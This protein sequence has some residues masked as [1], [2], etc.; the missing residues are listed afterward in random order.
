MASA[1]S[2]RPPKPASISP[3][4]FYRSWL[5]WPA[6]SSS[7][8]SLPVGN[9]KRRDQ[10]H[11]CRECQIRRNGLLPIHIRNA[12]SANCGSLTNSCWLPVAGRLSLDHG[13]HFDGRQE[14]NNCK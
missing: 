7:P 13:N 8:E 12:S 3:L 5:W 2:P 1:F 4:G 11:L 6:A 10:N 14:T 9:D